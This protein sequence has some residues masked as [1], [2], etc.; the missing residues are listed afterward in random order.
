MFIFDPHGIHLTQS[1]YYEEDYRDPFKPGPFTHCEIINGVPYAVNT[2]TGAV[3]QP[4]NYNMDV[5]DLKKA[6]VAAAKEAEA[7]G[8][9]NID[10]NGTHSV[11]IGTSWDVALANELGDTLRKTK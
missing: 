6:L 2:K 3:A 4:R 9:T 11:L 10:I 1:G 7:H 8:I 5:P